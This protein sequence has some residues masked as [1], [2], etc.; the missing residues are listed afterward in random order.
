MRGRSA[1][2]CMSR[3]LCFLMFFNM[4]ACSVS[5]RFF[6]ICSIFAIR[7]SNVIGVFFLSFFFLKLLYRFCDVWNQRSKSLTL[8]WGS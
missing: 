8:A 3:S 6:A 2:A 1:S 5:R 7:S 4:V